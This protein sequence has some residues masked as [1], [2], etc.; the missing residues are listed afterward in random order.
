MSNNNATSINAKKKYIEKLKLELKTEEDRLNKLNRLKTLIA[1]KR[2]SSV[3]LITE[4][5]SLIQ[6]EIKNLET[7]VAPAVTVADVDEIIYNG[8]NG[9]RSKK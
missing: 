3:T 8:G 1:N 2:I 5:K 9:K 7:S 6:K 4:L